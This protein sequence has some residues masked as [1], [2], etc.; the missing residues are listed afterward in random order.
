MVLTWLAYSL[1]QEPLNSIIYL[2]TTAT[3]W[4]DLKDWLSQ[5]LQSW[6]YMAYLE[7]INMVSTQSSQ[8]LHFSTTQYNYKSISLFCLMNSLGIFVYAFV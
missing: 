1:C 5:G 2:S 4:S 3:V 6:V 7:I 8:K